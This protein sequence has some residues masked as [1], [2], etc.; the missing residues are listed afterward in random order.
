MDLDKDYLVQE[1]ISAR[2]AGDYLKAAIGSSN[3]SPLLREL[4]ERLIAANG[5]TKDLVKVN[6]WL[7]QELELMEKARTDVRHSRIAKYIIDKVDQRLE[8]SNRK[9]EEFLIHTAKY[10]Q[11]EKHVIKKGLEVTNKSKLLLDVVPLV[12]KDY[13]CSTTDAAVVESTINDKIIRFSNLFRNFCQSKELECDLKSIRNYCDREVTV[14]GR[15]CAEGETALEERNIMIQGN[16]TTD[17]GVRAQVTGLHRLEDYFLF[18]GQMVA[19]TGTFH[20]DSFGMRY[21]ASK[22]RSGI[23]VDLPMTSSSALERFGGENIHMMIV[24]GNLLTK[25]VEPVNFEHVFQLIKRDLPHV[26]IFMGP[27][28]SVKQVASS[29]AKLSQL[30]DLRLLMDRF[31]CELSS[32]ASIPQLESTRF[33]IVPHVFDVLS[34][35]PLPQPPFGILSTLPR[36][37]E[38]LS[39]PGILRINGVLVGVTACDPISCIVGDCASRNC[40]DAIACACKELLLQRCWFPTYPANRLP[41][42]YAIDHNEPDASLVNIDTDSTD[43]LDK[44][45]GPAATEQSHPVNSLPLCCRRVKLYEMDGGS[46]AWV[47]KGTGFCCFEPDSDGN[48]I[49]SPQL[50]LDLEHENIKYSISTNVLHNSDYSSQNDTIIIWNEGGGSILYRAISFQNVLGHNAC[51][52]YIQGLVESCSLE[53]GS[54]S[55]SPAGQAAGGEIGQTGGILG[56]DG[57]K[58]SYRILGSPYAGIQK[59]EATLDALLNQSGVA[60]L[61]YLD[62]LDGTWLRELFECMNRAQEVQDLATLTSIANILFRLVLNWCGNLEIMHIFVSDDFFF[63]LLVAFQYDE[64]LLNQ[65]LVLNHVHFVKTYAKYHTPI[66]ISNT[67]IHA[68][69]HKNYRMCY[70]KDVVLPRHLDEYSIQR[71]NGTIYANTSEVLNVILSEGRLFFE[72][73]KENLPQSY[74]CA[75]LLRELLVAAKGNQMVS[76]P[77]RISLLLM[78]RHYSLLNELRGYL[79]GTAEAVTDYRENMQPQIEQQQEQYFNMKRQVLQM[80]TSNYRPNLLAPPRSTIMDPTS[81]VVDIFYTCLE[82]F[83]SIVRSAIFYDAETN[84]SPQMLIS[85]CRVLAMSTNESVQ[86]QIREILIKLLDPK[87]MDL[88]EKDEICSLFYDKGVVDALCDIVAGSCAPV[89]NINL[90]ALGETTNVGLGGNNPLIPTSSSGPGFNRT[91]L[92]AMESLRH[93]KICAMEIFCLCAKEHRH[94]FKVRMHKH[95]LLGTVLQAALEPFDKFVAVGA[96]KFFNVCIKMKDPQVEREVCK[97]GILRQLLH[98]LQRYTSAGR[99]GGSILESACLSVLSTIETCSLDQLVASI[100]E[101]R[102]CA[103]MMKSLGQRYTAIASGGENCLIFSNL[104][105]MYKY[106]SSRQQSKKRSNFIDPDGWFDEDDDYMGE[107]ENKRRVL[108]APFRD[109]VPPDRLVQGYDED[110]DGTFSLVKVE[111]ESSGFGHVFK[112]INVHLKSPHE[113]TPPMS[114][115]ESLYKTD[116][117]STRD[118]VQEF[119]MDADKE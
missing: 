79:D 100:F 85:F 47:D 88:P 21:M 77:D 15:I 44:E 37:V 103:A 90:S 99:D 5:N 62:L 17:A 60:D 48:L 16:S 78:I 117:S 35:F 87:N 18:S 93:A 108:S 56:T 43:E 39:N 9:E 38:M 86:T 25:N 104:E 23:P 84:D 101:D 76:Q 46:N 22:I 41:A 11:D 65:H 2:N 34:S 40:D 4:Q 6:Q 3:T 30:G 53:R 20:E 61:V 96:I 66:D 68:L 92:A 29:G 42:E 110:E 8:A 98:V 114:H 106:G 7:K 83:P 57:S 45:R 112:R 54:M 13:K 58:S 63:D 105:R 72:A 109:S 49:R 81:L 118:L 97:F 10:V 116:S 1:E 27:F 94:R 91:N 26:C 36:N 64:E 19:L 32:V 67:A 80:D 52:A 111:S 82:V 14:Y 50:M 113:H 115:L 51:W 70:L 75:L 74:T 59:I 73:L 119:S 102:D 28:I 95:G 33:I 12:S 71:L 107:K 31:I 89:A 24:P 69:I 55:S